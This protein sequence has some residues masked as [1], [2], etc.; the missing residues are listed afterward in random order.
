M[1]PPLYAGAA[2]A[3][4]S[5]ADPGLVTGL[6][7]GKL[8]GW[9]GEPDGLMPVK[10]RQPT[11][12]PVYQA[13]PVPDL[14]GG[15]DLRRSPPLVA[16][17]RS[18][19][20]KNWSL[21]EPGALR[22]RP[23]WTSFT[24]NLRTRAAQGTHRIYLSSTQGTVIAS[25]GNLYLLPDNG[26]WPST[27]QYAGLSTSAE[28]HF[29]HDRNLAAA[30]DGST[31]AVKSTDLVTWTRLG[32][33]PSTVGATAASEANSSEAL[34]TSEF[35]FVFTYKDRGLAYE[36]DPTTAVSTITLTSTGNAIKLHVPNS[37][38]G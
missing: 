33:A 2:G 30:F 37:T 28:I 35:A 9:R 24:N 38:D 6:P 22:M 32:I 3:C 13:I 7:W 20:C 8:R 26:T 14:T 10:T 31:W 12:R 16:P 36:S 18:V 25:Q 5:A 11:A 19:V 15:L 21:A 4:R 1:R 17:E 27:S 23:G 34:S 29:I